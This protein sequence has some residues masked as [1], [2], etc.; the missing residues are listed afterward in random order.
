[1]TDSPAQAAKDP[2]GPRTA[3]ATRRERPT[4][5][6]VARHAG[7]GRGTVSRV[8]NET[9]SVSERSREAVLAAVEELGYVPNHAARSLVTRR[10]GAV[11]LVVTES[12]E[13]LWSEPYFAGIV[14]GIT[15]Q[16]GE[17]DIRLM[18]TFEPRDGSRAKLESYLLGHHVDGVMMVSGHGAD[19]LPERL[20]NAG[21][22]T[23]LCG[24][25]IGLSPVSFVDCDNR[26]GAREATDY[27][28]RR[29][30]EAIACI[31]GPQDMSVGVD[32]LAGYRDALRGRRLKVVEERIA[33]ADEFGEAAGVAAMRRIFEAD[34]G[35]TA[36]FAASD[37][38]A[39]GAI[40]AA[41]DRGR[42]VPSGLAVVGFDDSP[43]AEMSEPPLTT[44]H[45]PTETL[46]RE[47]AR[48]LIGRIRGEETGPL[49]TILGTHLVERGSA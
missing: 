11:A 6:T 15:E 21:V 26:S 37:P 48:L 39:I 20:E 33:V 41:R 3:R 28:A 2:G 22:P 45:Q 27:L 13:R 18:L 31:T 24:V 47:M 34:P 12:Q 4:L 35:V 29:G 23:V 19:P 9:G 40:R 25:P 38:L 36:V 17:D 10:T 44:V 43:L 7:V 14:R 8:V 46:G 32:R 5:D 1:M 42:D 30:H 16:L 49:V